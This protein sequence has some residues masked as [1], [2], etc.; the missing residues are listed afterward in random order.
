M[1]LL[2]N[3]VTQID[4][5]PLFYA[6]NGYKF[7]TANQA[8]TFQRELNRQA[9]MRQIVLDAVGGMPSNRYVVSVGN[10][11]TALRDPKIREQL[12]KVANV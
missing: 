10:V 8:N 6:S 2:V 7:P 5:S 3:G 4:R 11:I 1:A 12:L 9:K